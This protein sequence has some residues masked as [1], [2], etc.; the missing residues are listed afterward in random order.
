[1]PLQKDIKSLNTIQRPT[2]LLCEY[3]VNPIGIDVLHPIFSWVLKHSERGRTQSAYQIL[4]AST[5]KNLLN[6]VGDIWDSGKV[7][8]DKSVNVEYD[9]KPLK[10]RGIYYWKVKWWDDNNQVSPFSE[11]AKFDVGL[12]KEDDWKARWIAGGDL[13]RSQFMVDGRIKRAR[14]YICGLGYYELRINGEKV[15]DRIL[16]P[17]WTDYEKLVLYSTYD[18][19]NCLT[20]GQNAVGVILG[21]GRYAQDLASSSPSIIQP[22]IK[23]YG[24][25][26]ADL[27]FFITVI[28]FYAGSGVF[29]FIA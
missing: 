4:V 8:S 7:K 23:K 25:V 21:N 20:E 16:D 18:V 22:F 28:R 9:G 2:Y 29:H 27:P 10:S 19:T 24:K 12:L 17:G 6:D 5:I 15:G 14:A 11:I 26:R 1:M 3:M 13:F